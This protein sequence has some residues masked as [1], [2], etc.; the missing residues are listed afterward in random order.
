MKKKYYAFKGEEKKIFESW[1]QL[2]KYAEDKKGYTQKSFSSLEEANAFLE[3]KD[4]YGEAVKKKNDEG[5]VVAYTDGSYEEKISAYSYGAFIIAP[6]GKTK[7]LC[8]AGNRPEFVSTRNVAGE[9]FGVI[10]ALKWTYYNG[11]SKLLVYHDYEGLSKWASGEW[12]AKSP[13]SLFYLESIKK[14]LKI[15]DCSFVKVKGHSNDKYNDMVDKLAK[16]ALFI[17]KTLEESY[18]AADFTISSEDYAPLCEYV[19]KQIS[20][21]KFEEIDDGIKFDLK[22]KKLIVARRKGYTFVTGEKSSLLCVAVLYALDNFSSDPDRLVESAFGAESFK[23]KISLSLDLINKETCENYAPYILF[24]LSALSDRIKAALNEENIRYEKISSLFKKDGEGFSY[25][26]KPV[27]YEKIDEAYSFFY[28]YR[29]GY[30]DLEM[31]RDEARKT[32]MVA[33]DILS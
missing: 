18:S 33:R 17:G 14:Y 19:H 15:V 8:G 27:K 12:G 2:Q 9:I 25:C 21:A 6:D 1:D 30:A 16:D 10:E 5:F 11:Y 13:V 22:G 32:V 26:G 4:I 28:K 7:E 24:A 20:S 29:V 3:G 31:G 23:D